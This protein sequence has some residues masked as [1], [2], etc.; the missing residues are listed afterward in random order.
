M[1]ILHTESSRH[2][3]GQELRILMEMEGLAPYGIESVLATLPEAA[4]RREALRLGL[5][6][7]AVTMRGSVDPAAVVRFAWIMRRE[8]IQ[9]VCAHGSKDG[10]SA[11]L[12]ARLLGLRVVRCRHVANPI[13]SHWLGRLVYGPLCDRIVTTA[14]SIKRGMVERGVSAEKIVSIPTGV[15][16]SRFHTGVQKG[17]FRGELGL[18]PGR[19]L[20]GMISVL[21]GDKGPDVFIRAAEGVLARRPDAFMVLVGDGWMRPRLEEMA[22]S[23]PCGRSLRLTGYRRDIPDIM[24]DL[25]VLVLSARISEGVPQTILQAHAMLT[26]VVASRVGGIDE[27][28]IHEETA[29]CTPPGDVEALAEA[30]LRVLDKPEDALRRARAGRDMVLRHYTWPMTLQRMRD[31][32]GR[33]VSP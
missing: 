24:A 26:P 8:G 19:P 31:L 14:E 16:A 11:G 9:L 28:A 25:D 27:V 7:H 1:R 32:Y 2:L 5:R 15:D 12:A 4:I 18:E 29:L 17:R 21:R 33:M 10:W 3:G 13:R 23:S 22:R 30:V 20:I 6:V